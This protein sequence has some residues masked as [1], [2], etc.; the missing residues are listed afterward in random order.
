MAGALA[1]TYL[2]VEA[3]RLGAPRAVLIHMVA[4]IAIEALLGTVPLIGD[5][6]DAGWKANVRNVALLRRHLEGSQPS[7]V[8]TRSVVVAILGGL[9]LLI[10]AILLL[11][12]LVAR[13]LVTVVGR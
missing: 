3:A 2:V 11:V 9:G 13:S 4:N 6:F 7:E 10:A 1:S 12:I 8:P 5:V